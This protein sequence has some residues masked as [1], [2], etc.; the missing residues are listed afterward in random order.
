MPAALGAKNFADL[1]RASDSDLAARIAQS[2]FG[3][4]RI[5]SHIVWITGNGERPSETDR[6]FALLG[7]RYTVE[8]EVLGQ[9]IYDRIP[10]YRLMPN[11]LDAAFAV[12]GSYSSAKLL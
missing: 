10:R 8:S 4:Q 11:P 1:L 6:A 12:F 7:Q 3:T 5:S 9:V 2:S